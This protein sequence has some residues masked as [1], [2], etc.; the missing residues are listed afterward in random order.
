METL[1]VLLT[2]SVT[3]LS[4]PADTS[5][6]FSNKHEVDDQ[7][8]CQKRVLADVEQTD[9]LVTAHEDLRIVL[10]KR[11]L[12][13]THSGHVLDDYTM[14]RVLSRGIEDAVRFNHVINDS[15]LGDFLGAKLLV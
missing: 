3:T 12:V 10:I 6:H 14:I 13:V 4:L 9:S 1:V 11:T 2:S 8:R 5:H 15:R 7:G